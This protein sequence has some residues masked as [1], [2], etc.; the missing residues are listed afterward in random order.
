MHPANPLPLGISSLEIE[1]FD[2]R[3]WPDLDKK[4]SNIDF[5]LGEVKLL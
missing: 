1:I 2:Q 3:S 5:F 4:A